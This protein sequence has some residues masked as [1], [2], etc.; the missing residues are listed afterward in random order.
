MVELANYNMRAFRCMCNFGILSSWGCLH[1]SYSHYDLI[2]TVL[3]PT[4]NPPNIPSSSAHP[5]LASSSPPHH[6]SFLSH[7]FFLFTTFQSPKERQI[8]QTPIITRQQEMLCQNYKLRHQRLHFSNSCQ[9][10]ERGEIVR[11]N[12]GWTRAD[13][14]V[15][16]FYVL[17]LGLLSD[18]LP[19]KMW[20]LALEPGTKA[21][22][23]GGQWSVWIC[24]NLWS[25]WWN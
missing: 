16:S 20:R 23:W 10:L 7:S 2:D 4:P 9:P 18:V 15:V 8:C 11:Q 5:P 22:C 6:I 21:S 12:G 17:L 14:S 19:S 13:L 1:S 25:S 3:Q 24:K